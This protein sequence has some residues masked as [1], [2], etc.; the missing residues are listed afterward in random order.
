MFKEKVRALY[1]RE[2]RVTRCI[3]S[4]LDPRAGLSR[5][6]KS[7]PHRDS[8]LWPSIP[9][10]V[11]TR[12]KL[13]RLAINTDVFSQMKLLFIEVELQTGWTSIIWQ[14]KRSSMLTVLLVWSRTIS[15]NVETELLSDHLIGPHDRN[16]QLNGVFLPRLYTGIAA[17]TG[18]SC[19]N[20]L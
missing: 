12:T 17:T 18:G 5:I 9:Y 16:P 4:C 11:A 2:L 3:G 1:P 7:H 15:I 20:C 19:T 8:N 13:S 14:T 6:V 10:Q